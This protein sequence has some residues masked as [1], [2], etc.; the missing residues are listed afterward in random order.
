MN[1][2]PFIWAEN[3]SLAAEL[4][5]PVRKVSICQHH[6]AWGPQTLTLW[7]PDGT[8]VKIFSQMNDIADRLEIGVLGFEK[9]TAAPENEK[10]EVVS[11]TFN[12][13]VEAFKLVLDEKDTRAE[14]GLA[15]RASN[16]EE[17]LIIPGAGPCALAILLAF[18]STPHIFEPEYK[19][20]RCASAPLT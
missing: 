15:L 20:E 2:L 7:H 9:V 8:G 14:C 11:D 10:V 3:A 4:K 18:A 19:L 16:G 13:E 6:L 17:I 5:R 1:Y 12:C